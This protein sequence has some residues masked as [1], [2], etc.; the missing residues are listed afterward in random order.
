MYHVFVY[1]LFY[2]LFIFF[3]IIIEIGSHSCCGWWDYGWVILW[4]SRAELNI[5]KISYLCILHSFIL[6]CHLDLF[7]AGSL[8][9]SRYW[10]FSDSASVVLTDVLVVSHLKQNV[11]FKLESLPSFPGLPLQKVPFFLISNTLKSHT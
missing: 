5:L 3:F 9:D 2:K 8:Y 4:V 1:F 10:N 6:P 11:A 7:N